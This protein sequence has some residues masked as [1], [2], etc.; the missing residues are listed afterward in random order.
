MCAGR[1]RDELVFPRSDGGYLL[2]PHSGD[3]WFAAAL[4]RAGLQAMTDHDLRHT[5]ASLGRVAGANVLAVHPR[6]SLG[7]WCQGRSS[8]SS[9]HGCRRARGRHSG[10]RLLHVVPAP[11]AV[12]QLGGG[13]NSAGVRELVGAGR[14]S[15]ARTF[16]L[17]AASDRPN[18]FDPALGHVHLC[19]HHPPWC[20]SRIV[21]GLDFERRLNCARFTQAVRMARH[22]RAD[23]P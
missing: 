14:V 18:G 12:S 22:A 17:S 2:R 16:E 11:N 21:D 7:H 5:C 3:G 8:P 19:H 1:P 13:D 4:R 20:S 9:S 15:A 10:A 6:D 23:S